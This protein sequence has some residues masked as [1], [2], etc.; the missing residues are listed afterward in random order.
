MLNKIYIYYITILFVLESFILSC[1]LL[2]GNKIGHD[3]SWS[4]LA[5]IIQAHEFFLPLLC[6]WHTALTLS[7]MLYDLSY[8][9]HS[10]GLK[11]PT[12]FAD[13]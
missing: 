11:T 5:S 7:L 8:A 13:V 9:N 3:K 6:Q 10:K 2:K 1:W 4:A 12:L